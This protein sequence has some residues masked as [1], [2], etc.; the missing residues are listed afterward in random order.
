MYHNYFSSLCSSVK[1]TIMFFVLMAA[2]G[3]IFTQVDF[4]PIAP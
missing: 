4:P 1:L 3:S 2:S